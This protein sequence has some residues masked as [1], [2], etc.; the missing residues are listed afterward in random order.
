MAEQPDILTGLPK[1]AELALDQSGLDQALRDAREPFVVRGL[2]AHWPLVQAALHGAAAV[3]DYLVSHARDRQFPVNIGQPGGGD[4]LFYD[5]AMDVNF[6]M[7]QGPLDAILGGIIANADK[8]D[9]PVI[10]LSSVD[11]EAY[12]NGLGAANALPLGDR[13]P[14][15]SIWIG[16]RTRIAAHNDVPDNLAVCAAGKRRFIVFPPGQMTNLYPGPLDNT[17]AGRPVS[18]V[19]FRAPDLAA[20]PRFAQ[21]LDHALVAD[22]EPGDAIHVPSLWWHHV[23]GQAAFNVL[24]NYWWRD[25]P[26]FLGQ[27]EDALYHAILAIRDLPDAARACWREQFEHYVFSGGSEAN[28]HLPDHARGVLGP[29]SAET[30]GQI[31]AKLLRGLSR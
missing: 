23:E 24:V 22:L 4:R 2:A 19:D 31:K 16:N 7:A 1:V 18:M 15:T 20:H 26:A 9:A 29:L 5:A 21:A 12:F 6:Q 13:E 10:Y 30:A 8:R 17:P 14:I 25:V 11:V 27:P 28:A 3:K